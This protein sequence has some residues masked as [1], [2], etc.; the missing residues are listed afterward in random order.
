MANGMTL[1][2][3]VRSIIECSICT[4]T[5]KKPK[6]LPCQH[7][8]CLE[9]LEEHG[10]IN[11]KGSKLPCPMCRR[12]FNIPAG[13][14][15]KLDCNVLVS[16][17]IVAQSKNRIKKNGRVE[18][19]CDHHP[20]KVVKFYCRDCRITF[21]VSC[22]VTNHNNHQ[23]SEKTE[24]AGKLEKCLLSKCR[25]MEILM[26]EM[27]EQLE[28]IEEYDKDFA[29]QIHKLEAQVIQTGEDVKQLVDDA[30]SDLMKQLDSIKLTYSSNSGMSKKELE[31]RSVT[32]KEYY[33]SCQEIIDNADAFTIVR[34]A[35]DMNMKA[36]ELKSLPIIRISYPPSIK[37]ESSLTN[38]LDPIGK[39][40]GDF[41]LYFHH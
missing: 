4:R 7:T 23:V 9:C 14:L 5:M 33:D 31:S 17:L 32:L 25:D 21:C 40:S 1:E 26:K 36:N 8:F 20:T 38:Q 19:F 2:K 6:V 10:K 28:T 37:F 22:Y 30:V 24:Y 29:E 27:K 13:G 11:K 35:D 18:H 41:F 15:S 3:E 12:K 39:F 34:V 16:K